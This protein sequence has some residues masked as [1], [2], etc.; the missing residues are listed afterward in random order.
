MSEPTTAPLPFMER[1][2]VLVC[3]ACRRWSWE[4]FR[5]CPYC[6]AARIPAVP[7]LPEQPAP[8]V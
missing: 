8:V 6:A 5:A 7:V 3:A 1:F 4:L 2:K